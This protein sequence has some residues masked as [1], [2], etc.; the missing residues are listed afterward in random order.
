MSLVKFA[1]LMELRTNVEDSEW[2]NEWMPSFRCFIEGCFFVYFFHFYFFPVRVMAK[3]PLIVIPH[4]LTSV[5]NTRM[6]RRTKSPVLRSGFCSA[7]LDLNLQHAYL[8]CYDLLGYSEFFTR[9]SSVLHTSPFRS[10]FFPI[11]FSTVRGRYSDVLS[12]NWIFRWQLTHTTYVVMASVQ[13]TLRLTMLLVVQK[14][15]H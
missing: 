1:F 14:W 6:E 3:F 10:K 7:Q 15:C 2:M 8:I 5:H 4:W 9:I 12:R 13:R 11:G